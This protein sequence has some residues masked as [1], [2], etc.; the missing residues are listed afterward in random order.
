LSPNWRTSSRSGQVSRSSSIATAS[1]PCSCHP[2]RLTWS[3]ARRW[4]P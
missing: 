4:P 3:G 2:S 1:T